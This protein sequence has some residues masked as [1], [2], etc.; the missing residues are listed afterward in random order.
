MKEIEKNL[1]VILENENIDE[2]FLGLP[3]SK[4]ELI[5]TLAN[6][7]ATNKDFLNKI[8]ANVDFEVRVSGIKK[9]Q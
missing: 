8:L 1:K 5:K 4:E 6:M 3:T 2:S 7:L 9:S